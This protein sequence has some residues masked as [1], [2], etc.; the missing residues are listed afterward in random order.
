MAMPAHVRRAWVVMI[1]AGWLAGTSFGMMVQQR[2]SR[3]P[4]MSIPPDLVSS[5]PFSSD[6]THV[7]QHSS[8]AAC[9]S[10]MHISPI[11]DGQCYIVFPVVVG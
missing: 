3:E 9:M 6:E 2:A 7:N 4:R 10:H 1:A 8:T 5:S 11:H